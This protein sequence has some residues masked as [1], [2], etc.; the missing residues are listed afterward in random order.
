MPSLID[1]QADLLAADR[2]LRL[3]VYLIAT[4]ETRVAEGRAA[5]WDTRLA[6][7]LLGTMHQTLRHFIL[8]RQAIC[9]A[10]EAERRSL[11]SLH[12]QSYPCPP[13]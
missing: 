12:R 4:Q 8:H 1:E 3:A 7:A 11:D 9:E 2:H 5:G 13:I 10:I 6:E